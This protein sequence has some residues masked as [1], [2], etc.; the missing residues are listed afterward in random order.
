VTRMRAAKP[1]NFALSPIL[2]NP[3]SDCTLIAPASKHSGEW[4]AR[5]YTEIHSG[6]TVK[7]FSEYNGRA[8]TPQTLSSVIWRHYL[9]LGR[10]TQAKYCGAQSG[11]ALRGGSDPS[12]TGGGQV[13]SVR[14]RRF[15]FQVPV[16]AQK[17]LV[18]YD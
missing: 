14:S 9:H 17:N 13:R 7:L 18:A 15:H 10:I 5:D 8:L 2:I 3:S 11:C 1:Y 6:Q 12:Q 4:L 16:H